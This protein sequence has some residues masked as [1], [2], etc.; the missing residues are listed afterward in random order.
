M[1]FL[2][3]GVNSASCLLIEKAVKVPQILYRKH[4][5]SFESKSDVNQA[6]NLSKSRNKTD[7]KT[8]TNTVFENVNYLLLCY[9]KTLEKKF[10]I[11]PKPLQTFHCSRKKG[12]W[13]GKEIGHHWAIFQTSKSSYHFS[14]DTLHFTV[15][16]MQKRS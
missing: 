13:N 6:I 9:A 11:S 15:F 5:L 4:I 12:E 16:S 8:H 14:T 2:S 1:E 10:Y 7:C 3:L